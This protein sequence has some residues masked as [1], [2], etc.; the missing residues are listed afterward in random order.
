MKKG[1]RVLYLMIAV[2]ILAMLALAGYWQTELPDRFLLACGDS[3]TLPGRVRAVIREAAPPKAGAACS[4]ELML[5]FGVPVKTVTVELVD[6]ESVLVSGRPFGIKMF[7][8]GLIVVGMSDIS[9]NGKRQN[10]G[11]DAGLKT[12]DILLSLDGVPLKTNEQFGRLVEGSGG[13]RLL[14]RYKRNGRPQKTWLDPVMNPADGKY[15]IGVWVRDSSAGIGTVTYFDPKNRTFAGLG[16]PVCDV[17]TGEMLELSTGEAVEAA[18]VSCTKSRSGTPGELRGRFQGGSE[19]AALSGNTPCGVYGT[20]SEGFYP[21]GRAVPV[22]LAH[23]IKPGRAVM[24]TTVEGE[25]PREFAVEI[26]KIFHTGANG[27][28]MILHITDEALL[29]KTGGICQGMSGS[30]ILQNGKLV[31]AVTHVLVNDPT[32]GYGIFIE[33]MLEATG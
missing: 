7:T 23:E 9:Q 25:T 11:K 27:R 33:K 14:L 28:N 26:E 19:F 22:A 12:G 8:D 30:P 1:W 18:I 5:P 20:L 6:R 13:K 17:D 21:E 4:A 29:Q 24:L 15:H 10:P 16:H 32:R 31:G 2:P 3:I